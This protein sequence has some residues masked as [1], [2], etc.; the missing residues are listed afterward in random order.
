[1]WYHSFLRH[2]VKPT[3]AQRRHLATIL[4]LASRALFKGKKCGVG[5]LGGGIAALAA[6]LAQIGHATFSAGAAA[7]RKTNNGSPLSALIVCPSCGK[8]RLSPSHGHGQLSSFQKTCLVLATLVTWGYSADGAAA[9]TCT[10]I[11]PTYTIGTI[12]DTLSEG[13]DGAGAG[14]GL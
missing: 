8:F 11:Q 1:M 2:G 7:L 9:L 3:R 13:C 10:G 6:L 4:R 12:S 5:K 14:C